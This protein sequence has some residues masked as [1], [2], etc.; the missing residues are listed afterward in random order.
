MKAT[1]TYEELLSEIMEL[2]I[3]LE[4][5]NDAINAIKTGQVD[6]LVINNDGD[7]Q[8][9]TL[10][11]ADQTYRVFIEKMKEGAVTLNKDEIILYSNSQFA[12]MMNLPLSKVIGL[13][14]SDFIP[15][16]MREVFKVLIKKGWESD[17]KGEISLRNHKN[18]LVPF[19][20]S[21]SSLE[22]DEGTSL[23]IILTDLS[24]QKET[25]KQLKIKNEQLEEARLKVS[26]MN[27][28]L[29]D[30]VRIR[31]KDLL[32]SREHFKFL[33]DNIPVIVWTT[34]PDGQADYFNKKWYE[35]T[36][37]DFEQS[38]DIGA[39][40]VLHPDD[41]KTTMQAWNEAIKNKSPFATVDSSM[42][43]AFSLLKSF[44][45]TV[46]SVVPS[47]FHTWLFKE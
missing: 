34:Q 16:E 1:K 10:K 46:P 27:E 7:H 21:F 36:G 9:Y 26:K 5:S 4:E 43:D 44:I 47:V 12:S 13:P 42:S 40:R 3:Q 23:S 19:L 22:L 39:Q 14:F 15:Q 45:N 29:E 6:A 37:L 38:K 24:K 35:Y 28:E 11:S 18:K 25:E 2:R 41:V 17:S 20:L 33:A 8:L 32:V 31:T 30:T